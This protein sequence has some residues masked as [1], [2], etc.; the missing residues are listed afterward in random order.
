[1]SAIGAAGTEDEADEVGA[2]GTRDEVG[3]I[4][5][6]Q[7]TGKLTRKNRIGSGLIFS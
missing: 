6:V 2:T 1:M 3:G 5:W 4:R 7:H